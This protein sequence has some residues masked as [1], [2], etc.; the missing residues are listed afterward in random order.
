MK[1]GPAPGTL[2]H[3]RTDAMAKAEAAWGEVMPEEVRALALACRADTARSVAKRLGYSDAVVSHVLANRYP[4]DIERVFAAIRGALMGETVVCP[5]LDEI[6]RDRCL[7]E[8][9]R[10]FAA[11]NSIRA[12]LYHACQTCSNRQ[13]RPDQGGAA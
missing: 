4:G 10:P 7:T 9:K 1:R 2:A 6:G 12:R 3:N 11:T 13:L 8:Q 5:I